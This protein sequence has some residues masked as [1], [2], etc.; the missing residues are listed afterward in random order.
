MPDL[1]FG[2]FVS[3]CGA[4]LTSLDV[5]IWRIHCL[6]T[7]YLIMNINIGRIKIHE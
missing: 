7:L 2:A 3:G 4:V 1:P 6:E 5:Y